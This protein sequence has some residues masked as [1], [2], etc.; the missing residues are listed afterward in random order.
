MPRTCPWPPGAAELYWDFLLSH[1]FL[2]SSLSLSCCLCSERG[3]LK[4]FLSKEINQEGVFASSAE[5]TGWDH[6]TCPF[7]LLWTGIRAQGTD[8]QIVMGIPARR[9]SGRDPKSLAKSWEWCLEVG[10]GVIQLPFEHC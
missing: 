2:P 1:L 9:K 4:A 5:D 10:S 7:P 3:I 8:R 6:T